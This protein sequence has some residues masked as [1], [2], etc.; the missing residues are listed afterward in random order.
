MFGQTIRIDGNFDD[1]AD[2]DPI[3]V[4]ATNDGQSNGIDLERIWAYNDQTFLY[5]RF[6]LNKEINLQENNELAIYIDYDN[7]INTGFKIN[8][9]GSEVRLFFGDRQGIIT[10]AN[11]TEFVNFWPLGLMASPSVSGTEFEIAIARSISDSGL[12]VTAGNV[13]SFRLEDNGFNGDEAPNDLSGIDYNVDN[14]IITERPEFDLNVD[15]NSTFR[16]MTYNIE[17]DQLFEPFRKQNFRRIFQAINPD[18]IALQEVRDFNS[19]ETMEL[20]EE[21]LPGTWYHKKHGFDIVTISRYPINFS[22]NINGNGAFYLDVNGKEVLLVNCHL[23]CCEN[24]TD[25]QREVD[26]IMSY[27]RESRGG[28]E[29]YLLSEDTPI[30][31]A[32][33]M[34]F[35]G[36][37][38]QPN[39]F[40]TG[41]IFSNGTYG[42]DFIPDWDGT[43]LEDVDASVTGAL[44]NFTWIN[45]FGSF[46]PGKLDWVFYS[47]S[48]MKLQNSFSLWTAA[49]TTSELNEYELS[50]ADILNAAD[51]LPVVA[52]FNF[53]T[54]STEEFVTLD[55]N[56]FPNPV[57]DKM[58]IELGESFSS[59][60]TIYNVEGVKIK[61]FINDGSKVQILD[62]NEL[63]VGQYYILFQN[64]RGRMAKGFS[65][66]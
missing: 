41:D 27:I 54:V 35:V 64:R 36:D 34:N 40:I 61:S 21:F 33:D 62:L 1:W 30:I 32:G 4:D 39:T 43:N 18:V 60:F 38:D 25:R 29:D 55:V 48:Q 6:E 20:I 9:I 15:P 45:P 28:N 10:V 2:I 7:D 13:V 56:V 59:E 8:G 65:K 3:F 14:S 37:N 52:D 66:I 63:N 31:I 50:S 51:H 19:S 42:P 47:G 26:G 5:F 22:E 58:Y 11:N 46:F 57:S 24:D 17:N 16:F 12:N 44:T 49:M 23:P 53:S